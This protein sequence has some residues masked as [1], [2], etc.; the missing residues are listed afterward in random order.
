MN[1]KELLELSDTLRG[2]AEGTHVAS[3]EQWHENGWIKCKFSYR[4][5]PQPPPPDPYAE[6]KAAHAAG[7]TIQNA[8]LDGSVWWDMPYPTWTAPVDM[9]RIKPE[10]RKVPFGPDDVR[11][12]DEFTSESITFQW[13]AKDKHGVKIDTEWIT[14]E[15]L[16]LNGWK[17]RSLG[18]SYPQE[19]Y[20]LIEE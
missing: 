5:E 12:G 14:Y 10:P 15:D 4:H 11:A 6:L 8:S 9:Y 1:K 18:Q 7:K 19:C 17:K 20:K 16:I 13:T 3:F 2:I